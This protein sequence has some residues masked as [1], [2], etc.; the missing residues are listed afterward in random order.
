MKNKTKRFFSRLK[1]KF[2]IWTKK[3]SLMAPTYQ[4]ENVTYER[5]CFKI[6]LKVIQHIN[7]EFMIAPMSDK[8]YLKNDDMSIFITMTDRRVEITNH[9]FNYNVKL[10]TRDWQRLTN[11]FDTEADKRRLNYEQVINSQITNSLHDILVRVSN[12]K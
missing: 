1:L 4:E 6:C 5:T 2:Y 12:F 10:S 11:I 8:R 7:T 9:V 3:P